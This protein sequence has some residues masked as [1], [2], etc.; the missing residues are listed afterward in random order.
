VC[1][2]LGGGTG[3]WHGHAADLEDLR[4]LSGPHDVHVLGRAVA[5][6]VG[7]G[8]RAVQRHAV[9]APARRERRRGVL[10]RQRGAVRHLL[11]HA[12]ADERRA[13]AT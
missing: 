10:H 4:G 3:S 11:P 7:H 9:G 5:Q 6:G 8:R 2:S 13:T 1:H 12:Q